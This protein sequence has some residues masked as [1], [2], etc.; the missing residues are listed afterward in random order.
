MLRLKELRTESA[1]SQ[2][3][4]AEC[5]HVS[6]Q[7]VGKWE[8]GGATPNPE[9]LRKLADIFHVS[10][11]YLICHTDQKINNGYDD[12]ALKFA[13]FGGDVDD[14]TLEEVKRFA[15]F[16]KQRKQNNSTP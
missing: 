9:T 3:A 15:N 8:S 10:V 14:E 16:A 2:K 13:L 6:Q 1:M 7:T 5:L 4:L 12:T 11:D